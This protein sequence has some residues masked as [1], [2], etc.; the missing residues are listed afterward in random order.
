MPQR[1]KP[2]DDSASLEAWFGVELRNWRVQR[3]LTQDRL[4]EMAQVSGDLIGK[5]EKAQRRCPDAIVARLDEVLS[6]G[7]ALIRLW[8]RV[9]A[10]NS[11]SPADADNTSSARSVVVHPASS[12]GGQRRHP[13]WEGNALQRFFERWDLL[14]RRRE[15]ISAGG[16]SALGLLAVDTGAWTEPPISE[17]A[18]RLRAQM[19]NHYRQ[20]DNMLGSASVFR[21]A[22]EHHRQLV[23]W[24]RGADVF[25][26]G[27]L[28]SLVAD[29]GSLMAWLHTDQAQYGEAA[30]CYRQAAEASAEAGDIGMYAYLLSRMARI[31]NECGLPNEALTFADTAELAAKDRVHPA[32]RSWLA[33]TRA[34]AHASLGDDVACRRDIDRAAELLETPWDSEPPACIRFYDAAHLHKWTGYALI[35]LASHN[36]SHWRGA[37]TALDESLGSWSSQLVR[38]TAEISAAYASVHIAHRDIEE[39]ARWAARAYD[40]A[41]RTASPRNLGRVKDVIAKLK[42]Y[43]RTRA[44][45]DLNERLA[46]GSRR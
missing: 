7:G 6:A 19:T 21:Q 42:P 23:S 34:F 43:A 5:I 13:A 12:P 18:V 36:P 26:R 28:S 20:L 9:Q 10:E 4:G 41:L 37:R 33:L 3:G 15:F 16:M 38:G 39:A 14:M 45:R 11:A 27:M 30:L 17:D 29:S 1:P 31:L 44:V 46:S 35:H 24:Q 25:E 32:I 2:L 8:R 22:Q 40:V